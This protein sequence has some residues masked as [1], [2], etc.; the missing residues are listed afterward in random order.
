[1]KPPESTQKRSNIYPTSTQH[2]HKI[3]PELTDGRHG[4][5][6]AT[7]WKPPWRR[8]PSKSP[9]TGTRSDDLSWATTRAPVS[10]RGLS[11]V[12]GPWTCLPALREVPSCTF[13]ARLYP[14][15][16][17]VLLAVIVSRNEASDNLPPSEDRK[18]TKHVVSG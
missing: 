5:L 9:R 17:F 11:L 7:S 3:K 1:M 8:A 6:E 10:F 14:Q 12:K 16:V 2:Q 15:Q 13:R 18:M 4:L